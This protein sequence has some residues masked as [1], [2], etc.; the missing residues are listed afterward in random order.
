MRPADAAAAFDPQRLRVAR[1]AAGLRANQL[2]ERI[3][4]NPSAIS[5]YE[6]GYTKPSPA[7]LRQIALALGMPLQ[8]FAT[9]RP[10]GAVSEAGAHF[11]SLRSSS[12]QERGQAFA[13]AV[14]AWDLCRVIETKV[15]LTEA[16]VPVIVPSDDADIADLDAIADEVRA[17]WSVPDGPIPNVVRLMEQHGILVVRSVFGTRRVDAF[18]YDFGTRPIVTLGDDSQ[19]AARSRFDAAHELGHLVMHPDAEPGDGILERQAHGFA[20]AFLMPA[21]LIRSELP[22]KFDVARFSALRHIW[23]VSVA[24]LLYRSRQLGV[25]PE[26]TYRRAVT[27]MSA[28]GYRRDES[29]LG[30]LGPAERPTLLAAAVDLLE[31]NGTSRE[32]LADLAGL[33]VERVDQLAAGDSRPSVR[34]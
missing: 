16:A 3:D 14:I 7:T 33:P 6:H 26:N 22:G 18:S 9:T 29:R 34:I 17:R 31:S 4:V 24:A 32:A 20:A 1:L 28:N 11:R 13:G 25:M 27:W 5:Q 8:W 23:G 21:R 12:K 10:L 2:A 15:R 19:D 30:D